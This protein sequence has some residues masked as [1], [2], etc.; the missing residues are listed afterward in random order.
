MCGSVVKKCKMQKCKVGTL[1]K[2]CALTM[3]DRKAKL[4]KTEG[5][6]T[7]VNVVLAVFLQHAYKHTHSPDV[8]NKR[9][10]SRF[11]KKVL[12]CHNICISSPS[13]KTISHFF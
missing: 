6:K 3:A 9:K 13:G 2:P 10:H 1:T 4:Q 7:A 8:S 5:L 12:W 11:R